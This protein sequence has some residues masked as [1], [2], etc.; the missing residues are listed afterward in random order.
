[1]PWFYR[2]RT[3]VV[4]EGSNDIPEVGSPA[5]TIVDQVDQPERDKQQSHHSHGVCAMTS[6][7]I[8]ADCSAIRARGGERNPFSRRKRDEQ[9]IGQQP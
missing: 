6:I 8:V 7:D 2:E 9:L 5:P 4:W 1:M 3:G